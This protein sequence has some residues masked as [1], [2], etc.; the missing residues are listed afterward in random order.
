MGDDACT[1]HL[2]WPCVRTTA[3]PSLSEP[4][5]EVKRLTVTIAAALLC[6]VL[7]SWRLWLSS[8]LFPSS[9]ISRSLPAVAFPLDYLCLLAMLGLLAA[10]AVAPGRRGWLLAF[11]ALG[12]AWS[13][14]DQMR[15]QPW[16]YQYLC[17]LAAVAFLAWQRPR[18]GRPSPAL[19]ACRAVVVFTY[20]WSGVQKLNVTFFSQ[21]WSDMAGPLLQRLPHTLAAMARLFVFAIP[22]L[23]IGIGLGLL[24]RRSRTTA[25]V[26]ALV[27]HALV[28]VVLIATGENS[29]VWPWNIAM[30]LFVLQLFWRN[31]DTRPRDLLLPR[32]NLHALIVLL[33]GILPVLSFADLW[34]SYLSSALYSGNTD[35]AVVYVSPAVLDRLPAA[36]LPHVWQSTTPFFLDVNRWSYGEL[37]VPIYPEPRVFRRVAARICEYAHGSA[38]VRLLIRE[39]PDLFTGQRRSE[40]YDCDHLS[41]PAS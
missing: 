8:R 18:Q 31:D 28:L 24:L 30:G 17:M 16:Y 23:E 34:D 21:T 25:A 7:L 19:D 26:L 9:P 1:T 27:M 3:S 29:V 10:I 35:Q 32:S 2:E 13:L 33:V 11:L 22:P 36:I 6:G 12:V 20:L 39:K 37:N 38:G 40:L 15:W 4:A 5:P 41:W 14:W